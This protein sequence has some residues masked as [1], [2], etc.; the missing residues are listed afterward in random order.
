[1]YRS[2]AFSNDLT[3]EQEKSSIEEKIFK[4]LKGFLRLN[5]VIDRRDKK[6]Y[7]T[8]FEKPMSEE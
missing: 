2:R 6:P 5:R 7:F 4:N 1:M 8:G 3:G